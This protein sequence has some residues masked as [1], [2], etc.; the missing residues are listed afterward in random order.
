M[1][2]LLKDPTL[3]YYIFIWS[4]YF[5][6][7]STSS[8]KFYFLIITILIPIIFLKKNIQNKSIKGIIKFSEYP[9]I[10]ALIYSLFLFITNDNEI[11]Y[12][13]RGIS[14]GL[15]IILIVQCGYT[16]IMKYKHKSVD[17]LFLSLSIAY[18]L[19]TFEG[20]VKFGP[21]YI[22]YNSLNI[23]EERFEWSQES[24]I[25][26]SYFELHEFGLVMPLIALYYIW[27]DRT[28]KSKYIPILISLIISLMCAKRIAIGAMIITIFIDIL[29]KN[30]FI[31]K[32]IYKYSTII[33]LSIIYLFLYYIYSGELFKYIHLYEIDAKGRENYY[34][35]FT[36]KTS[37][38]I[39]YIG[40]G[41]GYI[42][43]YIETHNPFNGI[44]AIHND[45]L[46][47]YLE[48]GFLGSLIFF[49][50]YYSINIYKHNKFSP[51]L[52]KYFILCN[53]YS[54]ITYFTDNTL[55]YIFIQLSIVI[56]PFT[57]YFQSKDINIIKLSQT[58]K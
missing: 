7:L 21:S 23:S 16:I 51:V 19:L 31:F 40:Y 56:I 57:L 18:L 38:S 10:F 12:L 50:L 1:K 14:T 48:L 26:N 54:T 41:L 9:Y 30:K 32:V 3:Y 36:N 22:I 29:M 27:T 43:K 37:F 25:F 52:G 55:Y 58:T 11:S 45:I 15:K 6:S 13:F 46:R 44:M 49:I 34:T 42:S 24:S 2:D 33:I 39:D 4:F 53:I 20:I 5:S 28:W 47:I 8:I 17:F 35:Y